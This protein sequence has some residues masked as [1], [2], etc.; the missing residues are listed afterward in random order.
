MGDVPNLNTRTI[1]L[2]VGMA[3]LA[4][5]SWSTFANNVPSAGSP[6]SF[7]VVIPVFE[8]GKAFAV[9]VLPLAFLLWSV[10]LVAG[11][12]RLP[13]RSIALLLLL[14]FGCVA[15]F[16]AGWRY[17]VQYQG[18][19][20]TAFWAAVNSVLI[21]VMWLMAVR[22]RRKPSWYKTLLFHWVLFAWAA[23]CGFPWLGELI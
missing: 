11:E 12:T 6:Y 7:A 14:T 19:E 21:S 23:W 1:L 5:V 13:I 2:V 16:A 18:L 17:G 10:N 9:T 15:W 20:L 8:G 3:L 22:Y 4:V